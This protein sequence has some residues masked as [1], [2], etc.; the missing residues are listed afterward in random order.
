MI[1]RA[2]PPERKSGPHRALIVLLAALTGSFL[3]TLIV[4]FLERPA[5]KTA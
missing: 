4:L 2:I 5:A 3:A 1:D